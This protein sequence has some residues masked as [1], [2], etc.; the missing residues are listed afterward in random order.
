MK[1]L[2]KLE[3]DYHSFLVM[4][5]KTKCLDIIDHD[6]RKQVFGKF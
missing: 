1:S 5:N 4:L 6:N 2:A 3:C